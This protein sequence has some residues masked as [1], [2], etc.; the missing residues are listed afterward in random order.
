MTRKELQAFAN[1]S[2]DPVV[3][4]K[5]TWW[6][7]R[8]RQLTPEEKLRIGDMLRRHARAVRPDWPSPEE[9]REDLETHTRVAEALSRVPPS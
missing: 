5:E 3:R 4:Q 1:R 2:W 6:A 7:E 9:R 8:G